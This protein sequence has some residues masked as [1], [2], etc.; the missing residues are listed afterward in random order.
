MAEIE[1]RLRRRRRDGSNRFCGRPLCRRGVT[2]WLCGD[3]LFRVMRL[4]GRG[5]ANAQRDERGNAYIK[6]ARGAQAFPVWFFTA[7]ALRAISA[8]SFR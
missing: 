6:K 4:C 1:W 8:G 2:I 7:C 5:R 3:G